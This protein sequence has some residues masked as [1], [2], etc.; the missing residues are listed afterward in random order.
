MP[1]F[2]KI[3]KDLA[4]P[5]VTLTLLHQEF[6]NKCLL[7]GLTPYQYT[8]FCERYRRWAKITKATMR[9]QHKPGEKTEVDWAGD[10]LTIYDLLTGDAEKG[11]LFVAS[12]PC[13]TYVYHRLFKSG[14]LS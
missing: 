11:Y 9:I 14:F 3:H 4:K 5:G 10:T 6:V 13:S 7:E 12:L 2:A 8:Q 1:D